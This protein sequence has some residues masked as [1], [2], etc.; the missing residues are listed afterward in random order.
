MPPKETLQQIKERNAK[1]IRSR[2]SDRIAALMIDEARSRRRMHGLIDYDKDDTNELSDEDD[3]NHRRQIR[4]YSMPPV[5][6][7]E[8][9]SNPRRPV[10]RLHNS[11]SLY[12]LSFIIILLI[13]NVF[14]LQH[15]ILNITALR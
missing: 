6:I 9:S 12:L 10:S 3:Y 4:R 15:Y 11:L 1:E 5:E 13:L 2:T 8:E 14:Y 7:N